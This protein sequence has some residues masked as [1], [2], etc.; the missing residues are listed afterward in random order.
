LCAQIYG[1]K[2]PRDGTIRYIGRSVQ[3]ERR[4]QEHLSDRTNRLKASWIDDLRG[5]ELEPTLE[6]LEEVGEE[7]VASVI[8]ARWIQRGIDEGWPLT[9]A[10]VP[11]DCVCS[12]LIYFI[13]PYLVETYRS[14]SPVRQLKLVESVIDVDIYSF[15]KVVNKALMEIAFDNWMESEYYGAQW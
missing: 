5:E 9:N 6:I 3:P 13:E 11:D 15:R 7:Q 4:Y 8:E 2:D 1:L 10:T 14:M 12:E